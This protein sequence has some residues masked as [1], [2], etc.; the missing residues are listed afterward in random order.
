M[1]TAVTGWPVVGKAIESLG[2]EPAALQHI[3]HEGILDVLNIAHEGYN[4]L[5]V[6]QETGASH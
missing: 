5:I 6:G 3:E 1:A 2:S 4:K